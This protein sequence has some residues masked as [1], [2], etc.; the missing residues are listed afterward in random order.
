MNDATMIYASAI[1]L[2]GGLIDC[3]TLFG[4]LGYEKG[5][6]DQIKNRHE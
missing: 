4:H 2:S 6:S 3:G 1:V 5:R